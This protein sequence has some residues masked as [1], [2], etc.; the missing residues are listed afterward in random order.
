MAIRR[1]TISRRIPELLGVC[2]LSTRYLCPGRVLSASSRHCYVHRD[3]IVPAADGRGISEIHIQP[4]GWVVLSSSFTGSLPP[5][6]VH[7]RSI[8]ATIATISIGN[9]S[10]HFSPCTHGQGDQRWNLC[11]PHKISAMEIE[12]YMTLSQM[13]KSRVRHWPLSIDT[14]RPAYVITLE[15]S[16]VTNI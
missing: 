14:L 8:R 15:C 9:I 10:L 3:P 7:R 2:F 13:S 4:P 16:Y 1:K 5:I 6:S 12:L 11:S